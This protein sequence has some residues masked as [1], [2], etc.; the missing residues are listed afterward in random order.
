MGQSRNENILENILGAQNPLGDPQSREE[1]LLMQLLEQG[2]NKPV[3]TVYE[4]TKTDI[5]SE[6]VCTITSIDFGSFIIKEIKCSFKATGTLSTVTEFS[7]LYTFDSEAFDGLSTYDPITFAYG[8]EAGFYFCRVCP[9]IENNA[10]SC[11]YGTTKN[12][13]YSFDNVF[14]VMKSE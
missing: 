11:F 7:D 10:I 9:H 13:W 1:S 6:G 14:I 3:I 2:D 12:I 5:V 8:Y 4:G